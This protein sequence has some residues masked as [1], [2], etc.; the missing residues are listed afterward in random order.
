MAGQVAVLQRA[1]SV[2]GK[3]ERSIAKDRHTPHLRPKAFTE[4]RCRP[5]II[6][7]QPIAGQW[8]ACT[9]HAVIKGGAPYGPFFAGEIDGRRTFL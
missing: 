5:L 7:K 3:V 6:C 1:N 4:I 2:R 8:M 9:V